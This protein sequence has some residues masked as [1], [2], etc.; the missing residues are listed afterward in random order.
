[1][2]NKA[3]DDKRPEIQ[4]AKKRA[5]VTLVNAQIPCAVLENGMRVIS[6]TGLFDAFER[7]RKGEK[8]QENLPSIIGAKNLI[9]FVTEELREKA[10]VIPFLHSN[11]TLSFG[12]NAELIPLVCRV[13]VEAARKGKLHK[14]QL[15]SA[16]LAESILKA[17]EKIG[18][19]ALIDEATGEQYDRE[20]DALQKLLKLYVAEDFLKWQSR[21]PRK[22]YQEAFRI[23]GLN[24]NPLTLKRPQFLGHFTNKFVY[25]LMP[26]GVLETMKRKNPIQEN[27]TRAKKHHSLLTEDIGVTHLDRHLTK[28]IT[29]MELSNGKQD[30]EENFARVFNKGGGGEQLK[31]WKD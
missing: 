30:F 19:I 3:K 18:I 9:P 21:F 5:Y 22:F 14:S 2:T 26:P 15:R 17:L 12:Y 25:E 29:V 23:H 31:L 28:L 13:Y 10:V 20:K 7:P 1:M 4:T 6:Q 27:G 16:F 8:R 24:Y 11:G